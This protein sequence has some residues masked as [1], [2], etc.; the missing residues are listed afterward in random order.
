[1][2]GIPDDWDK[3]LTAWTKAGWELV[4]ITG[5]REHGAFWRFVKSTDEDDE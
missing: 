5:N 1:V 2:P 4:D 3:G